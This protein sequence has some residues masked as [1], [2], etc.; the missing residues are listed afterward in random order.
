MH[1]WS[2]VLA[3]T[4]EV[5]RQA[6]AAGALRVTAVKVSAA[7]S[8]RLVPELVQRAFEAARDGSLLDQARLELTIDPSPE[9]EGF[10]LRGIS[11]I[12]EIQEECDV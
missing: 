11:I 10:V 9:L 5:E 1:E 12:Q 2:L 3:L 7:E 4:R 8:L 6:R